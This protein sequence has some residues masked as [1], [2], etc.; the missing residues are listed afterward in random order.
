MR[1]NHIPLIHTKRCLLFHSFINVV[2]WKT[3]RRDREKLYCF[4]SFQIW[5]FTAGDNT[6]LFS[7]FGILKLT[8][9]SM[10]MRLVSPMCIFT[11]C[12]IFYIKY[13]ICLIPRTVYMLSD[14][15]SSLLISY[16]CHVLLSSFYRGSFFGLCKSS[17]SIHPIN[18]F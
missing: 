14:I 9:L 7:K 10:R 5:F 2:L 3:K 16:K 8:F 4:C 17:L 15:S 11:S 13:F 18:N 6:K 12:Y 1:A